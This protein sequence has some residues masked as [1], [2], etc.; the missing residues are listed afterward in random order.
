METVKSG[1]HLTIVGGKNPLDE[2]NRIAIENYTEMQRDVK[3]N[4]LAD[5]QRL[6]ITKD[7][8]DME[9]NGLTASATTWTYLIDDNTSQFSR[10]P[11]LLKMFSNKVKKAKF[12]FS[13]LFEDE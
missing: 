12:S 8:I 5:I 13:R 6:T 3:E 2:Y 1:I 10:L 9:E 7:G 4:V 11:E